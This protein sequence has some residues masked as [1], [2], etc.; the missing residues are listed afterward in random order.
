MDAFSATAVETSKNA[1]R[2]LTADFGGITAA[3]IRP[4]DIESWYMARKA[5]GYSPTYSKRIMGVLSVAYEFGIRWDYVDTNPVMVAKGPSQ[6]TDKVKV[7]TTST[8]KAVLQ[9]AQ[10]TDPLLHRFV[11]LGVITGARRSELLALTRED[12]DADLGM[13]TIRRVALPVT[14]GVTI[15]ERTKSN[16]GA[17]VI[18]IDAD[19]AALVEKSLTEHSSQWIFPG[20]NG[21]PTHP[22]TITH[23]LAKLGRK[24]NVHVHPHA[25][26]HYSATQA[27]MAGI[28]IVTVAARLGDSVATVQ[29]FYAHATGSGDTAA[30]TALASLVT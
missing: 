8:V 11:L 24:L 6:T 16:A 12:F 14:G 13:I 1:I 27:L 23:R 25:L 28:P 18:S 9:R 19:T 3:T 29:R 22:S 17:R 7:P 30:A 2:V 10:W 26:R 21:N 15:V 20:K 5:S 4:K